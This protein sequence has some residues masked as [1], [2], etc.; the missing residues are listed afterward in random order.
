ML[1][2]QE[3]ANEIKTLSSVWCAWNNRDMYAK[4]AQRRDSGDQDKGSSNIRKGGRRGNGG[5]SIRGEHQKTARRKAP[6]AAKR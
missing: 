6:A 3:A 1:P 5:A 2:N 4:D